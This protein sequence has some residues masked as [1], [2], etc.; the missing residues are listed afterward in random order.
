[1]SLAMRKE[2]ESFAMIAVLAVV[3]FG[4]AKLGLR[5]QIGLLRNGNFDLAANQNLVTEFTVGLDNGRIEVPSFADFDF[6][7]NIDAM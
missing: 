4:T 7:E 1:M 6:I 5:G 2:R 3:Y